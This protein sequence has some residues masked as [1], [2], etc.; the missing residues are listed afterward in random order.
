HPHRR[1]QPRFGGEPR[2]A[3]RARG[4]RA[5]G[6]QLLPHGAR[7][8]SRARLRRGAP[9]RAHAR[10]RRNRALLRAR[11]D[12]PRCGL[13]PHDRIHRGDADRRGRASRRA[14]R[15]AQ[16]RS[17]RA[18]DDAA[19]ATEGAPRVS[20]PILVVEDNRDLADNVRE[21]FEETGV[22][23]TLAFDA[24]HAIARMDERPYDLAIIDVNLPQGSGIE[25]VPRFKASSPHADV[26]LVTGDA[27][28]GSAIEAVRQGVF[29]Y[30]Q[31]PFDPADLL[32]LA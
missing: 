24:A 20:H 30:V 3:A 8:R 19:L 16:A 12:A 29:A 15:P 5:D 10:G 6:A 2:R 1:R 18:P 13:P 27:T 14:R 25:L 7:A 26:V 17:L 32:A 23:V 22:E 4:V 21:L 31:K 28:L 11:H 9:R